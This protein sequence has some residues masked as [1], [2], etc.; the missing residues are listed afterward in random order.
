VRIVGGIDQRLMCYCGHAWFVHRHNRVVNP[1]YLDH[2]LTIQGLQALE[3]EH[4]PVD[5]KY[6]PDK[7][8]K[9]YCQCPGFKPRSRVAINLIRDWRKKQDERRKAHGRQ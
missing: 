7:G 2:P 9:T 4:S 6:F 1:E 3:C 5:W 8:E